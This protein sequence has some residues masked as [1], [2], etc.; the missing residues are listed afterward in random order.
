ML[1]AAYRLDCSH[2]DPCDRRK[3]KLE[4][5]SQLLL[6]SN[7]NPVCYFLPEQTAMVQNFMT[8]DTWTGD[9][10]E[11]VSVHNRSDPSIGDSKRAHA[12]VCHQAVSS[13]PE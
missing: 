6:S 7:N 4:M 12:K 1:L 10:D 8:R 11:T 5:L 2:G 13:F 9:V 3:K